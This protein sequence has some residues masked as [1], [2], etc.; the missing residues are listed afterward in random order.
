[1]RERHK[2]Y[3]DTSRRIKTRMHTSCA[4]HGTL[5]L[6]ISHGNSHVPDNDRFGYAISFPPRADFGHQDASDVYAPA[7]TAA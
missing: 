2:A 4:A 3:Q 1:M 7:A 5:K 6:A